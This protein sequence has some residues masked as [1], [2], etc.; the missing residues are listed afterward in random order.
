MR[1]ARAPGD[2]QRTLDALV[3]NTEE[4]G[5]QV[6]A[7]LDGEIVVDAWAGAADPESAIPVDGDTLF[8][9][10][11][12][13]KG[14][15]ATCL[16]LCLERHALGY[17]L[18]VAEIWPEFAAHGKASTTLRHILSH[19]SGIPQTPP[20]YRPEWLAD[21]DLMCAAIAELRPMFPPGTRT[22]YQSTTFGYVV[23]EVLRRIDGRPISR[24][25]AEEIAGP[26]DVDAYFGVPDGDLDRVAV[27]TDGPPA[28][29]EYQAGLVGEPAGCRVAEVF[30]RRSMLQACIP[31]SGG[32]ASAL[33]LARHYLVLAGLGKDRD[34][35]PVS[36]LH[37]ALAPQGDDRDAIYGVRIR[38]GLG[39]R[40]GADAGPLAS[41][42][43]F[44]HVGGGGSFGYAD[45][46][47][48]LAVGF[49]KNY[50]VHRSAIATAGRPAANAALTVTEAVVAALGFEPV[51]S[52]ESP[53]RS[54]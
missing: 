27:L 28:P 25:L 10:S 46:A 53:G 4:I 21:W 29:A 45:P 3:R 13:T 40:L 19:R 38:R 31:G 32:V 54:A 24:F 39:Y 15:A 47:R 12:A 17:D 30:N 42:T 33:G 11:S 49:T 41:P 22:A 51:R 16:H 43:A 1:S 23:G 50:F 36:R 52:R 37:E 26:F 2:V 48:R 34:L 14:I 5:L 18:P 20:G 6:A 9:A 8:M 7:F 35:L 44:G